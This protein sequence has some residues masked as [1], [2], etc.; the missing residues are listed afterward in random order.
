MKKLYIFSFLLILSTSNIFSQ[1][2]WFWQ[3]PLPQGKSLT[4]IYALDNLNIFAIGLG[5]AFIKSTDGGQ[6]WNITNAPI[7]EYIND[8][9]FLN[10]STGFIANDKIYKTT[11]G[12]SSWDVKLTLTG[13][14]NIW[15]LDLNNGILL[16][17]GNSGN[18]YKTTDLGETWVS[19]SC[20]SIYYI[21][22]LDNINYI[23]ASY[24]Y[25]VYRSSNSG[26]DWTTIMIDSSNSIGGMSFVNQL[27]GYIISNYENVSRL[28]VSTNSGYNWSLK[29]SIIPNFSAKSL[30]FINNNTGY[31]LSMMNGDK[32][33]KT[34]NGGLSW[35]VYN[36]GST[37][38]NSIV[39]LNNN[40]GFSVGNNGQFLKSTNS[41][42]NWT[43]LHNAIT[44]NRIRASHFL[45]Q[46][47][48]YVSGENGVVFGT[49]NGGQNWLPNNVGS[50]VNLTSIKFTDINTGYASGFSPL[51]FKTS[52]RGLSW[53]G[54]QSGA[55]SI[56]S[57][58]FINSL[59]G[60]GCGWNAKIVKTTNSGINWSIIYTS[61][62]R[63]YLSID[64]ID[65]NTGFVV[66]AQGEILKTTNS[67]SNWFNISIT[68]ANYYWCVDF[69]NIDTG[70]ISTADGKILKTTNSGNNWSVFQT[71]Y[72][73]QFN[74]ISFLNPQTGYVVGSIVLATSNGGLNWNTQYYF[75]RD[76]FLWDI[77]IIDNNI[78]YVVG[79]L[80][81]I[82]K[83]TT[84]GT[85]VAIQPISSQIP[86]NY[87][88]HQNYPNPFNPVTKIQF[89]IPL[90]RGVSEG[91]G[92]FTKI[93]IY[94]LLGREVASL[95]N[96][97]LKPGSYSV[98]WDGTGFASGVYFYSLVTESFV[99]TKRMVLVK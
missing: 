28:L 29:S 79:D 94:D 65:E 24:T 44:Y 71:M 32:L 12:G 90:S 74:K 70:Y 21:K 23:G 42:L 37:G 50:N 92:M 91:R 67:G 84:G 1:S 16:A 48:G 99:E 10:P 87:S 30:N 51:I 78:V 59:T 89:Q 69:V 62:N 56:Y 40:F 88:L 17:G 66:S 80:G 45:N 20:P 75:S 2:G 39:L 19:N 43:N 25:S 35:N 57:L 86:Q 85:F 13:G 98:D 47:V 8:I 33:Y 31:F 61:S 9:S 41:G 58:T 22:Q 63:D 6:S 72:D 18:I 5:G 4:K 60:Y 46:S 93:L 15:T 52:N 14:Y 73:Q 27:T 11:N 96:E 97:Q 53:I 26:L 82:L 95:V 83:T 49:T 3:N 55:S 36:I 34:F 68:P 7:L 54:V 81:A 38:L 77:S 64:F 76:K